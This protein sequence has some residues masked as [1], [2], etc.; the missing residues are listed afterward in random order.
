MSVSLTLASKGETQLGGRITS[1]LPGYWSKKSVST[2][3]FDVSTGSH[4][5]LPGLTTTVGS[6]LA[7]FLLLDED[8]LSWEA[9]ESCSFH[10]K[11]RWQGSR[12]TMVIGER[13]VI[14]WAGWIHE[15]E[16]DGWKSEEGDK[17]SAEE[18]GFKFRG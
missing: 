16:D 6:C 14:R 3:C 4:D 10:L 7:S 2:I 1:A 8:L 15:E 13:K 17:D 12:L 9:G 18:S 5:S 11:L